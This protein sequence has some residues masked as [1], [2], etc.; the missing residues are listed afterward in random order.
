MAWTQVAEVIAVSG[1]VIV[2]LWR[3]LKAFMDRMDE[4]DELGRP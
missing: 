3:V 4:V 2:A 1:V